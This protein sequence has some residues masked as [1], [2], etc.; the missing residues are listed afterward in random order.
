MRSLDLMKSHGITLDEYKQLLKI[1]HGR[2]AICGRSPGEV[3]NGRRTSINLAVDHS[4]GE[5]II[6]GLLCTNCNLGIGSFFDNSEIVRKAAEYL[7]RFETLLTEARIK[8]W[9][10]RD[11]FK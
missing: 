11:L 3:G 8:F 2:C 6:R 10:Q 7:D 1:Q 9:K 4:H 5:N